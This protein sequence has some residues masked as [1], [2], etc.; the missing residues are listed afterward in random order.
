MLLVSCGLGPFARLQIVFAQKVQQRSVAQANGFIGFTL[1][2]D[3]E[4]KLDAGF[5][6][7]EFGITG[8]AQA[9]NG[10]MRAFLLKLSFKFAQLRDVLSAENSTVV[11]E[12]DHYGR[13]AL[14]QGAQPRRFAVGVR[15]RDSCQLTAERFSHAGHSLGRMARC[16]AAFLRS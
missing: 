14:P 2:V 1:V 4:R 8:V 10:Q 16:Q 11:T 6:A 9:D 7:E 13:P 15:E 12:E 3:Q 5:F